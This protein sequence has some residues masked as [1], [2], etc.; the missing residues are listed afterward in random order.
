MVWR[1]VWRVLGR[2]RR[3]WLGPGARGRGVMTRLRSVAGCGWPR[4][5]GQAPRCQQAHWRQ[6]G[7]AAA[8]QRR[9][10]RPGRLQW[11]PH[12]QPHHAGAHS[13]QSGR[14]PSA[15][16]EPGPR[17]LIA[18]H[19]WQWRGQQVPPSAPRE[20]YWPPY[21]AAPGKPSCDAAPQAHLLSCLQLRPQFPRQPCRRSGRRH[22][23][24]P[25]ACGLLDRRVGGSIGLG[26]GS[27]GVRPSAGAPNC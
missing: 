3:A 9:P 11:R 5:D 8:H 24:S 16:G 21:G 20:P 13:S 17:L 7:V 25:K 18:R 10:P 19:R 22:L 6:G 12:L 23:P 14:Q 27:R 4:G 2:G 15:A 1:P 26:Q